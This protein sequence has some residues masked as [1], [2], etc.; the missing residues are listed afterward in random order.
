MES[1]A[2][3]KKLKTPRNGK[4]LSMLNEIYNFEG[5]GAETQ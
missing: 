4:N 3:S 1:K 5:Y 2:R